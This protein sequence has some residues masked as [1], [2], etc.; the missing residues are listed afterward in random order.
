MNNNYIQYPDNAK[1][2]IYQSDIHF[3]EDAKKHIQI[4]IDDF[5]ATWESHG[6]MVKGTFTILYDAFIVLFVDEQGDRMC[7]TAQDNSVKLMK[8]LE[9]ELEVTLL[10]RMN[11][12][13]KEGGKAVLV[14]LNDFE[15]LYND[16]KINDETIVFNNTITTKKE[17]ETTWEVPLKDSWHKQLVNVVSQ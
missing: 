3:D 16:N 4:S 1:V 11:Q 14:K 7:G 8:R 5:I 6:K 17:F 9:Q 12:S 10:D 2:W 13:Y 15:T